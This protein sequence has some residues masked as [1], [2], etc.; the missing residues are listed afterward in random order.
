MK[1]GVWLTFYAEV[2]GIYGEYKIYW[3]VL[4]TGPEATRAKAQR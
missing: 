2:S 3:Q 1:K 4:N